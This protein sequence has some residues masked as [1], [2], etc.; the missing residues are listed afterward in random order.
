MQGSRARILLVDDDQRFLD[1]VEALLEGSEYEL[2]KAGSGEKAIGLLREQA[3]DLIATDLV[4]GEVDGFDVAKFAKDIQPDAVTIVL[5][6]YRSMDFAVKAL[7][8]GVDDFVPKP[9]A[10]DDLRLRIQ[11]C[12]EQKR[13]G[14]LIQSLRDLGVAL[15]AETRL[16][17]GLR[18]CLETGIEIS[19]MDCGGIYLVDAASGAVDLA[20]QK[21]LPPNHLSSYDFHSA[22]ATLIAAGK[23][24]YSSDREVGVPLTGEKKDEGL[25][26]IAI[27]PILH[28]H[29]VIGCMNVASYTL[30]EVPVSCR[31]A[32][33]LLAIQ[34]GSTIARLRTEEALRKSEEKYRSLITHIPDVTWTT[35]RKGKLVYVS[36]SMEKEYGYNPDNIY[37]SG[38]GVWMERVHPED[39][40]KVRKAFW[41][42][43]CKGTMLDVE[44]R[45]KR[46]DGEW[47]WVHIR[48]I[49]SYD[50]N[51]VKYADGVL[52]NITEQKQAE[53]EKLA[54]ERRERH[55]QKFQSLGML[56]GGIAHNFNNLLTIITGNADLAL[57][58]LSPMAPAC[59][60]LQAIETAA[61]RASAMA[62]QMLD[63]SG[64]GRFFVGPIDT[65]GIVKEIAHLFEASLTEKVVLRY[66]LAEDLPSFDGDGTQIR[67]VVMDLFT[68]AS[69]AIGN[70]SGVITLSTGVMDCDRAYWVNIHEA[71]RAG[72]DEP[73][74]AGAYTYFEVTDTGCGMDADAIEKV[75]D[76]FFTTKF[77]GRGLGMSAVLGIVR[78]H[79]GALKI[80]SEVGKGSTFRVLFPANE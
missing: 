40:R 22:R 77:T 21:E 44:C 16:D 78:G 3:F 70:D 67:Q 56:A 25:R 12:L 34:I 33:E 53:E 55:A 74:A 79:R 76:P 61:E 28:E 30:E 36:P 17:E 43:F 59:G 24:I 66:D 50:R 14:N 52:T 51:G 37:R 80:H 8:L 11:E 5:T 10:A 7:R 9:R 65:N 2:T 18:L 15:S 73:L 41:R 69:E 54:L 26:A 64:K 20:F 13:H 19:G 32:L 27:I 75:F 72:L 48:S 71:L 62:R 57:D 35:D 63:Y 38:G 46:E 68:N 31:K 49:T 45:I 6:G 4:M 29:R 58:Q 23:P 60:N 39:S 47:I 1:S 42:L